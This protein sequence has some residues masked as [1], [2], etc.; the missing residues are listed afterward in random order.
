MRLVAIMLALAGCYGESRTDVTSLK[1]DGDD[2]VIKDRHYYVGIIPEPRTARELWVGTAQITT[3]KEPYPAWH[4]SIPPHVTE[5]PHESMWHAV[6][7]KTGVSDPTATGACLL[8]HREAI[9][10]EMGTGKTSAA[11]VGMM[12]WTDPEPTKLSFGT[13]THKLKVSNRGDHGGMSMALDTGASRSMSR[14]GRVGK[15][16]EGMQ[17][18]VFDTLFLGDE[19]PHLWTDDA[20]QTIEQV[21]GV[22]AEYVDRDAAGGVF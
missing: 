11:Q 6:L 1:C 21:F 12:V 14:V 9:V 10:S 22:K 3:M 16:A 18:I 17:R 4:P 5:G 19:K 13:D 8:S 15:D 20:G 2:I 7:P